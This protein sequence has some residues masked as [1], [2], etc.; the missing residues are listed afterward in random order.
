LRRRR[1][2]G[3]RGGR[4]AARGKYIQAEGG[5]GAGVGGNVRRPLQVGGVLDGEQTVVERVGVVVTQA[6]RVQ[7]AADAAFLRVGGGGQRGDGVGERGGV[8][9]QPASGFQ[10]GEVGGVFDVAQND[11][12]AADDVA[13]VEVVANADLELFAQFH[14]LSF[15]GERGGLFGAADPF[16]QF[17]QLVVLLLCERADAALFIFHAVHVA[18][19]GADE[20]AS[21]GDVSGGQARIDAGIFLGGGDDEIAFAQEGWNRE[22]EFQIFT[23]NF[24]RV[25]WLLVDGLTDSGNGSF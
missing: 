23:H 15:E 4:A 1:G 11:V 2:R 13:E 16:V 6:G 22:V 18:G 3:R 5:A 24:I 20:C 25:A 14:G 7:S 21:G 19:D 9:I 12:G 17:I 10:G 8:G